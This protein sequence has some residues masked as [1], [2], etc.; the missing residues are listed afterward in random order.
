MTCVPFFSFFFPFF[1]FS[2]FSI[3]TFIL[4]QGCKQRDSD[5]D[6]SRGVFESDDREKS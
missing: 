6:Y 5:V 3:I 1:S 4:K 2:I